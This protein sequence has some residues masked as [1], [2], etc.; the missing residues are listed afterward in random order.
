MV[1]GAKVRIVK[2]RGEHVLT[3]FQNDNTPAIVSLAAGGI[4][5][6]VEGFLSVYIS[7]PR[8]GRSRVTDLNIV[9]LG[10]RED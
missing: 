1:S 8:Q 2:S 10:I 9:S 7:N 4:A 5:G 3:I 6:A